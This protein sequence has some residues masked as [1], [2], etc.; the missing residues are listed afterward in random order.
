MSALPENKIC[1]FES[2]KREGT[3]GR[4]GEGCKEG[5]NAF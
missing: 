4:K 1:A 5:G 2:W 3:K